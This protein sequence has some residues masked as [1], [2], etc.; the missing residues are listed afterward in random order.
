MSSF[1]KR[2]QEIH[3]V[4]RDLDDA[5]RRYYEEFGIGPWRIYRSD[6]ATVSD[7]TL[8]GRPANLRI[9]AAI[10]ELG[11]LAL[12]LIEPAD[13]DSVFAEFLKE[14]GE[15]L[16]NLTLEVDDYD[17][18]VQKLTGRGAQVM[19]SANWAGT[20]FAYLDT[21]GL[22]G[23]ITEIYHTPPGTKWPVPDATYP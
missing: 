17:A 12:E 11:D 14:H 8:Y 7:A 9:R 4:V 22:L 19:Q 3:V 2:V 1:F 23:F 20:R 21:R 5:V 16:C 13:D 18:A 10:A 15:G 6:E